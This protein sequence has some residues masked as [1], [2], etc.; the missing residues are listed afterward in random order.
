MTS[1]VRW[2]ITVAIALVAFAAC[3]PGSL[4]E[5][6][7]AECVESGTQCRLPEGPLG[8]CERSTCANGA[9]PL[10]FQCVPQH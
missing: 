3:D 2:G 7:P 8:V 4:S 5:G 1:R 10:C 6:A 9:G